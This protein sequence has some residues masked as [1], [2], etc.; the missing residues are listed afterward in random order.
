MNAN[1]AASRP[2]S[3]ASSADLMLPGAMRTALRR[4]PS[5][6]GSA[7]RYKPVRVTVNADQ[8]IRYQ[9]MAA[10]MIGMVLPLRRMPCPPGMGGRLGM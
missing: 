7:A 6:P 4:E 8:M 10:G 1:I 3:R 5:E 9:V 2:H